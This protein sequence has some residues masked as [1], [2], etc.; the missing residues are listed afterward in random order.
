MLF[1]HTS[2]FWV[3]TK[4]RQFFLHDKLTCSQRLSI[5]VLNLLHKVICQDSVVFSFRRRKVYLPNTL[6]KLQDVMK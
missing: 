2:V 6:C 1:G 3:N 4:Q 5:C